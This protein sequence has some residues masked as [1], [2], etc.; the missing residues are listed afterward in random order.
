METTE[1]IDDFMDHAIEDKENINNEETSLVKSA[2]KRGK[3]FKS[4]TEED[5]Q[6]AIKEILKWK[7]ATSTE[8]NIL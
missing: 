8:N 7:R 1:F 5:I 4:H 3:Y 6:K 2:H